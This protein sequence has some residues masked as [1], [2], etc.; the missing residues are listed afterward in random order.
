MAGNKEETIAGKLTTAV[1]ND[2]TIHTAS[3]LTISA[4]N[5]LELI[6]GNEFSLVVKNQRSIKADK[7]YLGDQQDKILQLFYKHM[8]ATADMAT[9]LQLHPIAQQIEILKLK[10]LKMLPK[11]PI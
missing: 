7:L 2:V 3:N 11:Q 5:K 10:L 6:T 8:T 1:S 4:A 9:A